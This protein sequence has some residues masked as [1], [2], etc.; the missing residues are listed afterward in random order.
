MQVFLSYSWNDRHVADAIQTHFNYVKIDVIRDERDL[1]Y[2][3]SIRSFMSRIRATDYALMIITDAYLKS[4]NCMYEVLEVVK[5]LDYKQRVL[6]IVQTTTDVFT[7]TG[8][9]AYIKHWETRRDELAARLSTV[10]PK[11]ATP[12]LEEL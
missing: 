6:P 7:P 1:D 4:S 8:R 3:S 5:D 9:I 11:N 2:K 12:E 10:E